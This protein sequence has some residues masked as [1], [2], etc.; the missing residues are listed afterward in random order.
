MNELIKNYIE[1]MELLGR[2]QCYCCNCFVVNLKRHYKTRVHYKNLMKQL[3]RPIAMKTYE[4]F[5]KKYNISKYKLNT[6]IKKGLNE[7]KNEILF[8]EIDNKNKID[9]GLYINPPE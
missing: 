5:I 4:M 9:N 3:E 2:K 7:L 6:K 1:L 8:Y